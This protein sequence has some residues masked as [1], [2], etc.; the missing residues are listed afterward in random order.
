MQTGDAAWWLPQ[1]RA[2]VS[3][4]VESQ[5]AASR[6]EAPVFV[7][8]LSDQSAKVGTRVRFLVELRHAHEDVKVSLFD[9]LQVHNFFLSLNL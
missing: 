3:L 1:A 5:A 2:K 9:Y 8:T 4:K 6:V 7:R